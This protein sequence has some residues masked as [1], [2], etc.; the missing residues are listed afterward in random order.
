MSFES[1]SGGLGEEGESGSHEGRR[2]RRRERK[3]PLEVLD[4]DQMLSRESM[5][6]R[7]SCFQIKEGDC[8][9]SELLL[10]LVLLEYW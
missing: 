9:S 2:K 8:V 3:R 5:K 10:S 7:H 6:A 4:D 1:S